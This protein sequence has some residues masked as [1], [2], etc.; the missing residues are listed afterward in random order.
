[1]FEACSPSPEADPEL[2]IHMQR[3]YL[4]SWK[5]VGKAEQRLG[6]SRQYPSLSL[7]LQGALEQKKLHLCVSKAAGF[8][9]PSTT[10]W[11]RAAGGWAAGEGT[12]LLNASVDEAVPKAVLG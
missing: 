10:H 5:R 3:K 1:M 2:R 11:R 12:S 8:A 7:V 4:G 9:D 6:N